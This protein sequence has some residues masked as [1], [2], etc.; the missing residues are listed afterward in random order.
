M[1]LPDGEIHTFQCKHEKEFGLAAIDEAVKKQTIKADKKYL[2]LSRI[3]SS[4]AREKIAAYHP[5]W[6]IWDMEDISLK[7]RQELPKEEKIKLVDTFFSGQH[8]A[9]LGST[10]DTG[11]WQTTEKFFESLLQE[12]RI[13]N[14][15]WSLVGRVSEMEKIRKAI[16][17]STKN[18]ILIEGVGG[19]GKSRILKEIV[20][21]FEKDNQEV[22]VK[23]LGYWQK[24]NQKNLDDLEKTRKLLILDDAHDDIENLPYLLKYAASPSNNAKI[25]LA[26]RPYGLSFI[27]NQA[28]Q[29]GLTEENIETVKLDYL[30]LEQVTKLATQVLKKEKF[31]NPEKIATHIANSTIDCP[32]ATVIGAQIVAKEK[33]DFEFIKNNSEF[34]YQ[35][36]SKFQNVII[37]EIGQ[38]RGDEKLIEKLLKVLALIQPFDYDDGSIPAMVEKIEK[39][40][41]HETRRLIPILLQ[42]GILF[43]RGKKF[44]L[45]PDMLADFIIDQSCIDSNGCSTGYSECLFDIADQ[46]Y[47]K[48]I[49][50]FL[51][52]LGKLDWRKVNGKSIKI[53]LLTEI[54]NKIISY[55]RSD[56][57]YIRAV[58]KVAYYQPEQALN[59]VKKRLRAKENLDELPEILGYIAYNPAYLSE[60]CKLLWDLRKYDKTIGKIESHLGQNPGKRAIQILS[61]L[62]EI[63]PNRSIYYSEKIVEFGLY[64]LEQESSWLYAFTPFNILMPI[65]KTEGEITERA[66]NN[67]I[68]GKFPIFPINPVLNLR[69]KVIDA[70]IELLPHS[71]LKAAILAAEFLEES[72]RH[73]VSRNNFIV[74]NKEFITVLEKIERKIHS[75]SLNFLVLAQIARSVSWHANYNNGDASIIARRIISGLPTCIEFQTTLTLIDSKVFIFKTELSNYETQEREN[76]KNIETLIKNLIENYPDINE[77]YFFVE[78]IFINIKNNFSTKKG[79][80]PYPFYQKLTQFSL[81]FSKIFINNILKNPDS[82]MAQFVNIP[83]SRLLNEPSLNIMDIIHA[84]LNS[85]KKIIYESVSR[86]YSREKY[87]EEDIF[88]I[89]KMLISPYQSVVIST[90]YIIQLLARQDYSQA[91]NLLK[92]TDIRLSTEIAGNMLSAF[93][94]NETVIP[95]RLLTEEDV[96]NFIDKL[97]E[98]P[99]LNDY[100]IDTFLANSS[101]YYANYTAKFFM[102][103][104]ELWAETDRYDYKPLNLPSQNQ[105]NLR[106]RES[107]EFGYLTDELLSWIQIYNGNKSKFYCEAAKLLKVIFII[108]DKEFINFLSKLIN[109]GSESDFLIASSLLREADDDFVFTNQD[110]VI[111]YL[112]KAESCGNECYEIALY[113]LFSSA[114]YGVRSSVVGHPS[115][116]D[117]QIKEKSEKILNIISD[118]SP[119][120][121]LYKELKENAE[122]NIKRSM[123]I[124]EYFEN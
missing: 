102:K 90:F 65:L 46:E 43:K 14:H 38:K 23:F 28:F 99:N 115:Q 100:W 53:S 30:T 119:A 97:V 56:N 69:N 32:L 39:I 19:I 83:L 60:A 42:S 86:C 50:N 16:E 92:Q 71:N 33:T 117:V 29:F 116:K 24:I 75:K 26:L 7:I 121:R 48:H 17:D 85:G 2:L 37:G 52:N 64:L 66:G 12:N 67:F 87:E 94:D 98:L 5:E 88:I 35:L 49:E 40:P 79:I 22:H 105:I 15:C 77:L 47:R 93:N 10:N 55:E 57:P 118:F 122:I 25:L 11:P 20:S 81:D 4:K 74:W 54:W 106:F 34:Y 111:K 21:E 68:L 70:A 58:T 9:L 62:C 27:K 6:D 63:R 8:L 41:S 59:F 120:Y 1:T 112:E 31:E 51:I 73:S 72:I 95:F 82:E 44:R 76:N 91:I 123:K 36:F 107:P 3:A 110:F 96:Q 124:Y 89:K 101:R 84:L 114:F 61:E 80:S 18:L 109:S 45:S 108:F 13:F 104:V 78:K 103:R 113:D